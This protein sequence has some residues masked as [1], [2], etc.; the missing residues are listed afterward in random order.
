MLWVR[1]GPVNAEG[2]FGWTDMPADLSDAAQIA[3][4]E[5]A[6]PAD[7]IVVSSDLSRARA[8][9][10]AIAGA[11]RRL[12]DDPGLRE[13][14]FGAWEGQMPDAIADER[15]LRDF[16]DGTG[17]V[18]PPGGESWNDL[19]DRTNRAVDGLVAAHPGADIVAVAHMGTILTQVQRAGGTTPKETLS[20]RIHHLS[21]TELL[22]A[23]EG[24][25]AVSV[26]R[27]P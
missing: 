14:H 24:W 16:W 18:R 27:V 3:R 26:N 6:L 19:A 17:S 7:A 2:L 11:R 10:D 22:L 12:P 13:I 5:A 25:T 15:R 21:V 9:A 4:L 8:T 20:Q 23:E 1:H